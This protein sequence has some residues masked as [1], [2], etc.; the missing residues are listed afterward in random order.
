M[1]AFTDYTA[2]KIRNHVLGAQAWTMP[3]TLKVALYTSSTGIKTNNPSGEVSDVNYT[4]ATITFDTSGVSSAVSFL[5]P[6]AGLTITHVGIV[7]ST[8]NKII[9]AGPLATPKT[10]QIG[11]PMFFP[12]G[13]ISLAIST[14]S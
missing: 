14:I 6:T 1:S 8:V 2:E 9:W 3:T 11:E 7:D 5:G 4:R 13:S 10:L 12:V